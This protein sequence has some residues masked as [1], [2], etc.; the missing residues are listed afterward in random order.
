M[1]YISIDIETTGLDPAKDQ[2]L[3]VGMVE[4]DLANQRPIEEL[5]TYR[6]LVRHKRIVGDPVALRMNADLIRKIS[7]GEQ[8][9]VDI[10]DLSN[11]IDAWIRCT[12]V[13]TITLAGK[14]I[15]AFDLQFL[16]ALPGWSTRVRHRSLDPVTY[17][18]CACGGPSPP[19]LQQCCTAAGISESVTHTAL[20]D[21]LLVVRLLRVGW[22]RDAMLLDALRV[23]A[24]DNATAGAEAKALFRDRYNLM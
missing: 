10:D 13:G 1:R 21:A 16:K 11:D 2:I 6:T 22:N 7:L 24:I 19:S 20:Q 3:E 14:N 17:F 15:G 4:D 12:D 18:L 8:P 5:R 9:I 23:I